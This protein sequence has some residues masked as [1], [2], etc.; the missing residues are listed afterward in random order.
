MSA[1]REGMWCHIE[2][3]VGDLER[4]KRFYGDVFGW[5]FQ[6]MPQMSYTLYETR[7]GGVGGGLW[8][9]PPEVPRNVV[10]YIYVDEIET[11]VARVEQAG[12]RLVNPKMEVPNSG[13]FALVADPDGNVFGLWKSMR[14]PAPPPA[15]RAAKRKARP[16]AKAKPKAGA[17]AKAKAKPK[18]RGKAKA[19]ARAKARA[20]AKGSRKT[21]PTPKAR[22]AKARAKK[23]GK[24][25]A[26]KR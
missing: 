22:A 15:K 8:N 23:G 17:K 11:A 5:K 7:P 14:P 4:A 21:K 6:D 12:G 25:K 9:P 13:W 10:N 24:A 19:K 26:R 16:A 20:M 18:P 1:I 2:M 3:P